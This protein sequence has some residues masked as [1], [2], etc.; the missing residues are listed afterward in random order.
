MEVTRKD[1]FIQ[2]AARNWEEACRLAAQPLLEEGRMEA[3]YVQTLLQDNGRIGLSSGSTI[4]QMLG[5][6]RPGTHRGLEIIQLKGMANQEAALPDDCPGLCRH[7]AGLYPE[8]EFKLLYSP[9]YVGHPTVR[10]CL[11]AEPLIRQVLE[12]YAD[13]DLAISSVSVFQ[14]GEK[15]AW[16]SYI[17]D[18]VYQHL[19]ELGTRTCFLGHFIDGQGE[20]VSREVDEKQVGISLDLLKSRRCTLI[21]ALGARKAPAVLAT[22]RT[23]AVRYLCVDSSLAQAILQLL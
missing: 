21:L 14:Q 12:R 2:A 23:G 16:A 17:S 6:L 13:L 5:Q 20:I 18:E 1:Y 3:D 7:M 9:L 19:Y 22:L 8:S 10:A 15:S 11:E 4:R